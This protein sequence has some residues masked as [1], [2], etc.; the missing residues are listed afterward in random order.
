M[1]AVATT[2]PHAYSLI[3]VQPRAG[4]LGAEI[5]GVDLSAPI[6]GS[7]FAEIEQAFHQHLVIFLRNQSI[8]PE[9]LLAFSKRFGPVEP[10]PL[11]SRS[12]LD[13]H[14]EVMVLENKPGHLGP[15]RGLGEG[16]AAG[17]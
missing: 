14:P 2:V 9:D 8:S 7:L 12:G 6:D 3:E 13:E 5:K 10:H 4:T 17:W 11:G 1:A 15:R 16:R